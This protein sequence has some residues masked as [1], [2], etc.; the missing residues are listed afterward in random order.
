[1]TQ[2][3]KIRK[4]KVFQNNRGK[5]HSINDT[6]ITGYPHGGEGGTLHFDVII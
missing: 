1:M 4:M 2:I 3:K 6:E 5:D